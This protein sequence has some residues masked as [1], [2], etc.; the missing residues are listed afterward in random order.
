[1]KKITL[2]FVLFAFAFAQVNSQAPTV[3]APTPSKNAEDVISVY[4]DAYTSIYSDLSGSWSDSEHTEILIGSDNFAEYTPGGGGNQKASIDVDPYPNCTAMEYL[5]IDYYTNE[6]TNHLLFGMYAGGD[7]KFFVVATDGP[8]V[9]AGSWQS[10]DIPLS[11]FDDVTLNEV[12]W[13]RMEVPSPSTNIYLDNVYFWK[14]PTA[15]GSDASLSD[16]TVAGTTVADF[17]TLVLD[18]IVFE[19]GST[20]PAVTAS[21]TDPDATVVITDAGA[22]PGSTTVVVTSQNTN[23]TET[24]TVWFAQDATDPDKAAADVISVY[25]DTYTSIVSIINPGWGQA[26]V[27]TEFLFETNNILEYANLN[28]QGMEYTNSD[29]SGM[30]YV[31]LDYYT[32]DAT[33]FEFF[34]I[35]G[36]EN[37]YNIGTELGITK[38]QWVGVDIPLS[39]YSDAGRDLTNAFQFKTVGNGTIYLDNLYFWKEPSASGTDV[40]LSDLTVD[41]TTIDGFAATATTY[42]VDLAVGASTVPTVDV[43]TTDPAATYVVTDAD[44][45]PGA[46]T[47]LVTSQD[48]ST[49]STITVNFTA[50]ILETAAPDPTRDAADVIS[51]YSDFYPSNYT[52]LNPSWGQGTVATEVVIE[53]NNTLKYAGLN[54]Q[55]LDYTASDVSDMNYVHLDYFTTDATDIRF[56]VISPGAENAY[57]IGTE[58]GITTGEWVSVDIP[59]SAYTVPDLSAVNQ[60]KTEGNGT[61]Y[62]DNLYFYYEEIAAGTDAT[63]SDLTVDGTTVVGFNTAIMDYVVF[64]EGA[65]VPT[66][67]ASPTDAAASAVVTD[68][69]AVPGTT[70]IVVT[71]G[72]ASVTETYTITFAGTA[73]APA[74]DAADVLSIYSDTYTSNNSNL[75]PNWGQSTVVT[76]ITIGVDHIL[77]YVN[78]NYQGLEYPSTDVTAMEYIHLDYFTTNATSLKFSVISPG[79]ENPYDIGS[80]LGITTGEWVSI[81]I[82]LSQYTAP[83][84]SQVFQF[85]TEGDGTIYLDNL[86]YWKE[87]A[88]AG[89]DATLSDLTVDG[90]TVMDFAPTK[91]GYWVDLTVGTTTVPTVDGT[92]NDPAATYAVTPATTVPGATTIVVTSA[93]GNET[94][95]YTVNFT[96]TIPTAAA[97]TPD[98]DAANV[99]SV[100]SDAYTNIYTEL[101]PAWSQTTVF[102][103]IQIEA[104]NTLKYGHMNYQGLEYTNPTDVSGMTYVHLDYFTTDATA[105]EFFLIAGG[106]NAYNIGTENGITLGSWVSLDI[107]LSFYSDAGRDLTAAFQFKTVG[108]GTVYLDNLYF[109]LDPSIGFESLHAIDFSVYPNPAKDQV[110]LKANS[111]VVSVEVFDITGKLHFQDTPNAATAT[112]NVSS[113]NKGLYILKVHGIDGR[114]GTA[115]IYKQ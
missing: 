113:L 72:D 60:F 88:A 61:I 8:G 89:T 87:P 53:T 81:D 52:N 4:S 104:N 106:E 80:E 76:E 91:A 14:E 7:S 95:T 45:I 94:G 112:I 77:E 16:L 29:V 51:V 83:D 30:E 85:K 18:Y 67:V 34:L 68:A 1:M 103:E 65:T 28:Y 17:N 111:I 10:L 36:G 82:P 43:T 26:T 93:S 46:T 54:Y 25:S 24:Y 49:T 32:V 63:L 27:L 115:K 20:V 114:I 47:V 57:N 56:S 105:L 23:V 84:L 109:W 71:S 59:L 90:S 107:P 19:E 15:P 108:N 33:A 70:T 38:G 66:V 100:Y 12:R 97:P 98:K 50:T 39:Y 78:L 74:Q 13:I 110:Q 35:A 41:G 73:P 9:V 5:H 55:G 58:L 79:Q 42:T 64:I 2:L 62:L 101:N 21:T 102:E 6:D 48:A 11:F 92:P 86:Y 40:T 3:S 31:H 99:I 44:A 69:G 75:N 22:L 37:P 96:A